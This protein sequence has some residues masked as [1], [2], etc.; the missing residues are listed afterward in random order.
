MSTNSRSETK[1]TK[2]ERGKKKTDDLGK[3]SPTHSEIEEKITFK[4]IDGE[5]IQKLAIKE[6][7]LQKV[8]FFKFFF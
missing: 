4:A 2:R 1:L 7:E 6:E 8:S 3:L 5:D